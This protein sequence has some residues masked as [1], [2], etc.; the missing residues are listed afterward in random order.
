MLTVVCSAMVVGGALL[1]GRIN[2][3]DTPPSTALLDDVRYG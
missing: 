1:V 3:I 2:A